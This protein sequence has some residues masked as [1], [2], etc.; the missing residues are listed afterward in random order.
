MCYPY[1]QDDQ[2]IVS[3]FVKHPVIA[4]PEPPQAAQFALECAAEKRIVRKPIDRSGDPGP[5]RFG[6]APQFPGRA[7]LNPN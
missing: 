2:F 1:D 4:D 6:D 5:F 3:D 7:A